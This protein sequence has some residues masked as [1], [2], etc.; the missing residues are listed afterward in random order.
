MFTLIALGVAASF[1]FSAVSVALPSLLP[2]AVHG[3]VYFEAAAVIVSLV[4]LGQVL[5]LKARARTSS[6]I[7]SLLQLAPKTARLVDRHNRETDV[8]LD[9]VHP[10]NSLRV[11]PGERVPVDGEVTEG[12]S[13]IDESMITGEPLPVEKSSGSKVTGGTLNGSGSFVMKA[14]KVGRDTLLAQIVKLVNEAQRTRAPIQR[15]ADVVAGYFVPAVVAVAIV[16][17]FAWYFIGPEPAF[18]NALVNAIAVLIIAC[19]CALGL[20]TPMS[21]MVGTGRGANAGVLVRSA[22]ALEALAK[23]DTLV[24]DKTGTLTE[25]RPR[26]TVLE[27]EDL[28]YLLATLERGSEHP[29]AEA[30]AAYAQAQGVQPGKVE[31]FMA[32]PGKGIVGNVDGQQVA[33]GNEKLLE[34]LSLKAGPWAE[35]AREYRLGGATVAYAVVDGQVAGF[36]A[37]EDP[38]KPNAV[39]VVKKLQSDGVNVVMVSG[40][41]AATAAAVAQQAGIQQAYGDVLPA[42]KESIVADLAASGRKVAVAGD[43]VNDAPA[44][45]KA[46]VGIAMGTGT[47]IAMQSADITL[48]KGDLAG[49]LRARRLSAAVLANI[50]Q[51]LFFAFVYNLLGVPVAA[52]ILYPFFGVVLSPMLAALAMTFSSVS[53]ISNA[54]RLRSLKL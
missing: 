25:G 8:P 41:S 18:A 43:G 1:G 44:L 12:S 4:L 52:G 20:A 37:V 21:I 7:R 49:I 33:L 40:D 32:I 6:A 39:D 38:L 14:E 2:H 54:L 16:T 48:V 45:A 22:E 31:R 53:V 28:T 23:V 42:G 51:N 13:S 50:R 9:Q 10:G 19:P 27:P 34:T 17:F 5:E 47:D 24:I 36:V 46:Y 3:H 29:L 30:I 35:P 26:V 15:L 11:R